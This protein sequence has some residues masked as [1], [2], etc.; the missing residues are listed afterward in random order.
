V[1]EDREEQIVPPYERLAELPPDSEQQQRL[2]ETYRSRDGFNWGYDPYHFNAPEGSYATDANSTTRIVE[3][4]EMVAAVNN[5]GLRVVM[6]VVYNHTSQSGQDSKS[7]FD[8]IVPG[9]YHRLNPDGNVETS[10]CCQNTATEH[11]MMR[12]FMVESIVFWATQYKVDGFRFDLMGH[13]MLADMQ[14]VRAALDALTVEE[15]GVD[16]SKIYVYGEGWNFGEVAN[17]AR[18]VNATQ[19]NLFGSGIGT[20]SDRLRDAVRGGGPFDDPRVQGFATGLFTAPSSYEQGDAAAQQT[21]LLHRQSWIRLGLAGNL[22]DY[23]ITLPDGS[24]VLGSEVDYKG[25]PA[26]Y[27]A[28]P[29]EHIVYVSKHDNETIFDKILFA[30][31]ENAT[32]DERVRMN[33]L[34]NAVVMFSQGVPFF[35][36]GD[37]LL[38]SKSLDRN[39]YNSGD[40]FNRIDWTYQTN[41]FGVGLPTA[42]DNQERWEFAAP[43]LANP[44]NQVTP[45]Q[46]ALARDYFRE[47]LQIRQSSP[48]FR[49]RTGDDVISRVS[50]QDVDEPGV[51]TMVISDLGVEDLDPNT[52]AIVVVFNANPGETT[53]NL[54]LPEEGLTVAQ[55]PVQLESADAVTSSVT[56]NGSTVTVPGFTTAVFVISR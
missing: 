38:R 5:T 42:A 27:T 2:L 15:H 30:A 16:G 19:I 14:A 49:L 24:T 33:N 36:A 28:D 17:N 10:T 3:F 21:E 52:D 43:I 54:V 37:D 44:A 45:E 8:R 22:R 20:F 26:G 32:S 34:A 31:P 53:V 41:N 7:V 48:L 11:T 51:I 25:A 1:E 50:F 35:H 23:P 47:L 40:W 12:K 29:Q 4:R 39:S 56:V 6:D 55:H 18:G 13:H 46:I 9:Y